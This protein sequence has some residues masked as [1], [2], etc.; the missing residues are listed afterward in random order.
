MVAV[1]LGASNEG[2]VF[3]IFKGVV[4]YFCSGG[5]GHPVSFSQ[6]IRRHWNRETEA[7]VAIP[8]P[9]PVISGLQNP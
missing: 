1:A 7:N 8:S 9:E 6:C 2:K 3:R 4:Q 5:H